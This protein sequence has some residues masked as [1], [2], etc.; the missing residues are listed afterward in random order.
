M[1][2]TALLNG[3]KHVNAE[4]YISCAMEQEQVGFIEEQDAFQLEG[5]FL[6]EAITGKRLR[7][8]LFRA[9]GMGSDL[10]LWERDISEDV[11]LNLLNEF[12]GGLSFTLTAEQRTAIMRAC[13]LP[14]ISLTGGAGTGKTTI[15]NAIM[16][17]LERLSLGTPIYQLALSGRAAQRMFEATKRESSTITKFC[18]DWKKLPDSQRP[19]HCIVVIDEASMVDLNSMHSLLDLLPAATRFIFVGDIHQL[20]PVG[21]GLVYHELMESDFPKVELTAVQRQAEESGIHR[22]ATA[23][24]N[25]E[26][27]IV[28]PQYLENSELDCTVFPSIELEHVNDLVQEHG[29][30]K[31]AIVLSSVKQN[32]NKH[33]ASVSA[34][35]LYMQ[36]M[37]G[38]DRPV[39][40]WDTADGRIRYKNFDGV[41]FYLNDPVMVVKNDY[42][43]GVRNGDLGVIAELYDEP[44]EDGSYGLVRIDRRDVEMT[45]DMLNLL[46]LGYAITTHKS[47]GSQWD[48][49]ILVLESTALNMLDKN[50]LYTGATRAQ[51]KLIICCDEPDLI[52]KA[53]DRGSIASTRTT[54][55]LHH[56]HADS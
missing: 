43:I 3:L 27:D 24:R 28:V 4:T 45:L 42:T 54:N 48:T 49:V 52:Q 56:L 41:N 16:S 1:P 31:R 18:M 38:Y 17:I 53:V 44:T 29:G 46:D 6:V 21:G 50:L 51:K 47:Q 15:L 13:R 12:E 35:N 33:T 11:I 2:R 10:A 37:V 20:P 55:L 8:A 36:Q 22:F 23:V 7:D 30:H 25:Q 39:V 40:Q 19:D 26:T 5:N 14:V 9:P 32:A 34:L